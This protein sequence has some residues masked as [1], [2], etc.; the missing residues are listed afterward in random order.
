MARTIRTIHGDEVVLAYGTPEWQRYDRLDRWDWFIPQ[1][2]PNG[3]A[4]GGVELGIRVYDSG[5]VNWEGRDYLS[6]P[7]V[8]EAKAYVEATLSLE[9]GYES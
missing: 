1:L 3:M 9:G 4:V 2:L 7:S 6:F 5:N 8:E